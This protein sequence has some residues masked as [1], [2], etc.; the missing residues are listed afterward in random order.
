M[1][2]MMMNFK[3]YQYKYAPPLSKQGHAHNQ[4][5]IND[6]KMPVVMKRKKQF[7]ALI[8]LISFFALLFKMTF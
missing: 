7:V 2:N 6:N 5:A 3:K 8:G 4:F 1:K